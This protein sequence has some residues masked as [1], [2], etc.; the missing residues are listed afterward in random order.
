M[1]LAIV[2]RSAVSLETAKR[3]KNWK[4]SASNAPRPSLGAEE[5]KHEPHG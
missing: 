4:P 3:Q 5:E 1:S 2:Y